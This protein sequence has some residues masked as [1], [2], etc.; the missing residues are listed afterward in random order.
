MKAQ[1]KLDNPEEVEASMTIT[2]PIRDWKALAGQLEHWKL[3]EAIRQL[4]A[5][6]SERFDAEQDFKP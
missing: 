4:V 6:A 3:G 1:F 5:K 2:M